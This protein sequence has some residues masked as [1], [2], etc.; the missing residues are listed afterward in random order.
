MLATRY[1]EDGLLDDLDTAIELQETARNLSPSEALWFHDKQLCEDYIRRYNRLKSEGDL[2]KALAAG[3]RS[4]KEADPRKE[5]QADAIFQLGCA[6]GTAYNR[7]KD[8]DMLSKAIASV[9]TAD[10]LKIELLWRSVTV[11]ENLARLL[12]LRYDVDANA[13]D[14]AEAIKLARDAV[15]I[16][17]KLSDRGNQAREARCLEIL[18]ETYWTRYK[19][20]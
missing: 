17:R 16:L 14:G 11:K 8:G 15:D 20:I 2:E 3:Q 4:V 5:N 6:Q 19:K 18:G 7:T 13:E 1:S 9:K 10:Q 12:G